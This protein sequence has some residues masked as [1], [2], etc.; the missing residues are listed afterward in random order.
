M[1]PFSPVPILGFFWHGIWKNP[2]KL[3]LLLDPDQRGTIWK[4]MGL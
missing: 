1:G 3:L 4:K 2:V